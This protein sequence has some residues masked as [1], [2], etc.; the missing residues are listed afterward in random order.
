VVEKF[1]KKKWVHNIDYATVG[2]FVAD[3]TDCLDRVE[4]DDKDELKALMKP[5]FQNVK[6]VKLLTL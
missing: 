2:E 3:S 1:V 4:T 5:I 6:K